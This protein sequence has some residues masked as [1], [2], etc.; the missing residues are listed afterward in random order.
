MS[1]LRILQS[2]L[3]GKYEFAP[4]WVPPAPELRSLRGMSAFVRE[5]K[6]MRPDIVHYAG[7]QMEGYLVSTAL[8]LAGV[9][10]SVLAVHGSSCEAI[11]FPGYKKAIMR[12]LE[13]V[14]LRR[15][16]ACYG[17]SE[18]VLGWDAVRKN[19]RR[20]YGCIYNLPHQA[21][22]GSFRQLIRRELDIPDDAVV[23]VSTGRVTRE[24]GFDK[25]L[26]AFRE[27]NDLG[28]MLVVVGGGQY[29]ET[30]RARVRELGLQDSVVFTGYR[31]DVH[32]I[33][34]A[35]D[36]FTL[37]SMHETLG[38]SIIE[39]GAES[40]P[41]VATNVGGIPEI[42]HH[43][44]NGLLVEVG[45]ANGAATALKRLI[46][47]AALRSLMGERARENIQTRFSESVITG[48]IDALY[49]GLLS[50]Q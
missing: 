3:A 6:R 35:A 17:V 34:S 30:M 32:R 29:L 37:L 43:E 33:L 11:E 13:A 9:K 21:E 24:K 50:G 49:R 12:V 44:W 46:G 42:V 14:T 26:D 22:M 40:L 25:V 4:L 1:H 41:V 48:Q 5:I 36:I 15:A 38:N 39:A 2:S 10:R 20:C 8:V 31:A 18:Y 45:D 28:A 19:A 16:P 47:D 23:I 27:V 7:L